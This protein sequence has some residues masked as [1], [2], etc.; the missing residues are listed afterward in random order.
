[1]AA[2]EMNSQISKLQD[3]MKWKRYPTLLFSFL[4]WQYKGHDQKSM[5][6]CLSSI[7]Q[8]MFGLWLNPGC[9]QV[10]LVVVSRER[11]K[12]RRLIPNNCC[13]PKVNNKLESS[14]NPCLQTAKP[15]YW[16]KKE[17][18]A[19]NINTKKWKES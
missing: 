4:F 11:K 15:K 6:D 14:S 17:Y 10:F 8:N 1:V 2:G 5:K 7:G 19:A 16:S 3:D 9:F 12:E 18:I 13:Q